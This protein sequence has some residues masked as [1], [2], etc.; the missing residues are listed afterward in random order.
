MAV[1][2]TQIVML[3]GRTLIRSSRQARRAPPSSSYGIFR[4]N[5]TLTLVPRVSSTKGDRF[6]WPRASLLNVRAQSSG[7]L[8]VTR[9]SSS[10]P[11]SGRAWGKASM[12]PRIVPTFAAS[13]H[14]TWPLK[15]RLPSTSTV[16][17]TRCTLRFLIPLAT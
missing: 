13:T 12:P 14:D 7:F 15:N 8:A 9:P 2:G 4:P 16:A 5:R 6:A 1:S 3:P 10:R 17:F 11:S